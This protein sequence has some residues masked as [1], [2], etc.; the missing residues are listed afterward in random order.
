MSLAHTSKIILKIFNGGV[1]GVKHVLSDS[2]GK[3]SDVREMKVGWR[4]EGRRNREEMR[5]T[6]SFLVTMESAVGSRL[7]AARTSLS[8][9]S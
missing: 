1:F 2:R 7:D 8:C 5:Q 3:R 4:K 6:S 9:A